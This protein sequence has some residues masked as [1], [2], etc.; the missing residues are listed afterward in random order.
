MSD[1]LCLFA[2]LLWGFDGRKGI[3][4]AALYNVLRTTLGVQRTVTGLNVVPGTWCA[5]YRVSTQSK[6]STEIGRF[7]FCRTNWFQ[8]LEALGASI[9]RMSGIFLASYLK[10]IVFQ[11]F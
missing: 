5:V 10:T 7:P 6:T 9:T 8:E 2:I 4:L 11:P 1:L 3:W